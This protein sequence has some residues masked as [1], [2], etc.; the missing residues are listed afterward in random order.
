[1]SIPNQTNLSDII[2][3][4]ITQTIHII[5]EISNLQSVVAA[6]QI[7]KDS[8]KEFKVAMN[9]ILMMFDCIEETMLDV[10]QA[11]MELNTLKVSMVSR[12]I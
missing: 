1:M 10:H 2:N 9:S 12:M 7:T 5:T 8:V 6:A 11:M 4:S 3:A